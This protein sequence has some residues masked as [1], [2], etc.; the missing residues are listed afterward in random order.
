MAVSTQTRARP[1]G[2]NIDTILQRADM[3]W[4]WEMAETV[5]EEN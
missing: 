2:G 4:V 5:A 1:E 3:L